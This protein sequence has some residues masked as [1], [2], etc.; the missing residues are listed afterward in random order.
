LAVVFMGIVTY[1]LLYVCNLFL[2]TA[3]FA[4]IFLQTVLAASGGLII[5]FLINVMLKLPELTN[6]KNSLFKKFLK[7]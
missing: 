1:S 2:D 6:I 4:G 5:Y 7:I 3:T